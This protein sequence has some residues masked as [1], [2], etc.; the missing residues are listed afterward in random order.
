M[1]SIQNFG[2]IVL[3]SNGIEYWSNYSIRFEIA[4]I[5][6]ALIVCLSV[7]LSVCLANCLSV[8]LSVCV[9]VVL[10]S[11]ETCNKYQVKNSL[12]QQVYFAGEGLYVCLSVCPCLSVCHW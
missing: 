5:R 7:W 12:G 3:V 2:I 10:T 9:A 11:F 1:V 4:N 8:C 6:T